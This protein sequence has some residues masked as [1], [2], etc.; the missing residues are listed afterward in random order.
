MREK[1]S[2][3]GIAGKRFGILRFQ[4]GI[5]LF[6]FT[7]SLFATTECLAVNTAD[8][9]AFEEALNLCHLGHYGAAKRILR[10]IQSR[11]PNDVY[12]LTELGNAY[13]NDYNDVEG[14]VEKAEKCLR[15]AIEI[16]PEYGKAY[17]VLAEC[18]DSL[19]DFAEGIKLTTKAL[20]VKKPCP[21]AY[22]ERAGAYSRMK[23]DKEALA[24]IE[25][26]IKRCIKVERK[27]LIQRATIL[28]NLKQYDRALVEYRKLLKEKYEDQVVY[29]EVACLQAQHKTDEAIRTLDTLVNHNKQDDTGYLSRARLYESIG[30]HKEAIVDYSR[31]LDLQ[32]STNA[33]KER[34][35]VYEKM[36]RKDLA[37]KDRKEANRL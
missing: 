17:S 34:A 36:G 13:M 31:A 14:G 33:L 29:R 9:R 12:V 15:H 7:F 5:A 27:Y 21:D 1:L 6:S 3:A 2:T 20:A 11:H 37:E 16:D 18:R 28:E 32:P 24:D 35:T 4:V 30:K 8:E 10:G 25:E 26:Y 19:G 22:L 23:R